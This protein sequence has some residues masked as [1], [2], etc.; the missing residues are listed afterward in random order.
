[1]SKTK[2]FR[3][4]LVG[5][6]NIS[7][8]WLEP[9][10]SHPLIDYVGLVD[11]DPARAELIK[12][13][14]G[15]T[16]AVISQD[17]AE[18]LTQIRAD[19]LFD[20]AVPEAHA[21]ITLLALQHGCHVLGE[22]PLAMTMAEAGGMVTAAQAA[23][24]TLAVMQNRRF[25]DGV[26]RLRQAIGAGLI[27]ELTTLN[28]DFY[29]GAHFGGFRDEMEHVLLL[30][31]AIHSFDQ[32]RYIG[33]CDPRSVYCHEW[34]PAGS[35][36]RHGAAAMAIFEMSDGVV[37]NYRGSWAAEGLRTSWEC[38]W[39][40]IGTKG[41]IFW[42]GH[43]LFQGETILGGDGLLRDMAPLDIPAPAPLPATGHAGLL[44]DFLTCLEK[45]RTPN[46]VAADNIHSLAMVLAA[47][48]SSTTG[49]KVTITELPN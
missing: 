22:K 45:G 38:Q 37:F 7:H 4:I 17:L 26:I 48:E 14:Y 15:L 39:R 25:L 10:V 6:G 21:E 28:A 1:M 47:I 3:T 16:W 31:M 49:Q 11:L 30:D 33:A 34:N 43:D 5:C 12:E 46:T 20:C 36:Y 35:W 27:G 2:P 42:D 32:A 23:G 29:I 9:T 41:S 8:A 24:K 40:A 44:L 18:L 13:K 19:L